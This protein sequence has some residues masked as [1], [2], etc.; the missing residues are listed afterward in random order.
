MP[1]KV[2]LGPASEPAR[3]VSFLL[4]S[5]RENAL[6]SLRPGERLTVEVLE[7]F[8]DGNVM[9][10]IKGAPVTARAIGDLQVGDEVQVR[11]E[12][13]GN[14]YVLRR[15]EETAADPVMESLTRIVR[16]GVDGI[17][18][19]STAIL[20]LLRSDALAVLTGAKT[21]LADL[22]TR[23]SQMLGE[24]FNVDQGLSDKLS[25]LA[26]L[27]GLAPTGIGERLREALGRN[28]PGVLQRV[29]SAGKEEWANLGRQTGLSAEDLG[30]LSQQLG[31]LKE[32]IGVFR[33]LNALLDSRGGPVM[34]S[35][36][37][38]FAGKPQPTEIWFYKDRDP[39]QEKRDRNTSTALIKLR[40]SR[41]GEVRALVVVTGQAVTTSIF[42]RG[43]D[44]ARA[45]RD[46]LPELE[47]GLRAN[48]LSPQL[49][50]HVGLEQAP[51]PNLQQL[52]YGDD[53]PAL[54][55]RV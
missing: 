44:A 15:L 54:S 20:A 26:N 49:A 8:A 2:S 22:L 43:E 27:L 41:L 36:P 40:L 24:A 48:G 17:A 28:L 21:G 29:L 31:Q 50:V 33:A 18:D 32:Q 1:A 9:L 10:K 35:L 4:V 46:A 47:D 45:M 19:R 53:A 30:Q 23:V 52:L 6:A 42:V 55:V 11:V 12:R 25:A 14:T 37:L 13:D 38:M 5:R 39:R 7:K 16:S 51:E 3:Q 34:L